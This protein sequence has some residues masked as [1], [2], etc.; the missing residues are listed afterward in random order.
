MA[1]QALY[2]KWR[3]TTF[4]DVVG[5]EHVTYTLH[6]ALVSGRIAHAYLFSGP[7]GTGKTSCAR[8]LAKAV[9]CLD[10]D[11]AN[12]PCNVCDHCIAMNQGRFLDMIE[13]DAASHTSVDDVRELRDRVAFAPNEG[14]Y[15]VYIIDEVHR[16]SGAAFDALLKT[17]EEP[18]DH[19]IF[20]LATTEIHKVPQTI[21]SRCQRFDF[22]RIPLAQVVERL[23]LMIEE[24]GLLAE[25]GAL[26]LIARQGTGSLRDSISL[27]D[28]LIAE[29]GSV[30]TLDMAQAV[31]G[32]AAS[33][34]V[35]D[36]CNTLVDNDPATG[37][38]LI[39]Y[40]L[41]QGID[42]RQ[43][44]RQMVEYMRLVLLIQ[45]GGAEMAVTLASP[46]TV[47][48]ASYHAEVL[49]R[50][51]LIDSI[52]A[53]NEAAADM[54]GGWQ[55]QLPLE[56]ALLESVE[57]LHPTATAVAYAPA[58]QAPQSAPEQRAPAPATPEPSSRGGQSIPT[59]K[60]INRLWDSLKKAIR[61]H[62]DNGL[63]LEALL[64]S[65]TLVGLEGDT[66]IVRAG[67]FVVGKLN[68]EDNRVVIERE[69]KLV[70]GYPLKIMC[71]DAGDNEGA[72]SDEVQS[73]V[74]ED[75]V[76]AH[77]VSELGAKVKRIE[78]DK[79]EE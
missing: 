39:N 25:E 51:T 29:P 57:A 35:Q 22:R 69:L 60:E 64:N 45:T 76:V 61:Q 9:N 11:P 73:L 19:A 33:E 23:R 1:S 36:L 21:L 68:D 2:L 30:L 63:S 70:Y 77:A 20:V 48:A 32:T 62:A 31:L 55:P 47:S 66:I 67:G 54:R 3:P 38:E 13:I 5:Q 24:E 8:L 26:E 34:T 46:E 79:H 50:R 28:Q 27:L 16:F 58:E 42:A 72:Q 41:D 7:R 4:I 59:M 78:E 44:A 56:L 65:S 17:I 75:P 6:N 12:R 10:P 71:R 37:L 40:A 53:F 52:R 15:K 74:A 14:R 18:P 49:A 43:F